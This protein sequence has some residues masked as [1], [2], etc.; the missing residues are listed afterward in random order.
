LSAP[1][2]R[3][4]RVKIKQL[5]DETSV[6]PNRIY[7]LLR[8]QEPLLVT[9]RSLLAAASASVLTAIGPAR[10]FTFQDYDETAAAKAIKSG[11]PVIVHVYASWCL[12]CHAQRNILSALEGEK[13]YDR[14][15][16][17]RVDFD[18]QKDVVAA[19]A[20]PRSTLIAYKGG[21]EVA[22]MSWGV[23]EDDVVKVLQAVL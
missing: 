4:T 21:K 3:R 18:R 8:H 1:G 2:C 23:T 10:A 17:F 9:R 16:F 19:L 12:Q 22:R 7:R 13:K 14:L 5:R 11:A 6:R 20:S 15:R